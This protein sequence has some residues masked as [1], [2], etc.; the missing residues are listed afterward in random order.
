MLRLVCLFFLL[1]NVALWFTS[2]GP[3]LDSAADSGTVG[4]TRSRAE[5]EA[6]AISATIDAWRSFGL[7]YLCDSRDLQ[8]WY[9]PR[10]AVD[11]CGPKLELMAGTR[12][13]GCYISTGAGTATIVLPTDRDALQTADA[14][15]HEV[16]HFLS[17]CAFGD[18]DKDHQG[19]D[20]S[21]CIWELSADCVYGQAVAGI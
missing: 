4:D 5:L 9:A 14:L 15:A 16:L 12:I 10:N 20:R 18:A 1:A 17:E 6:A 3:S 7:P 11:M 2:C 13:G 19:L 21:V 8:V